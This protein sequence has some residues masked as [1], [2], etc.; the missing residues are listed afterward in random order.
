MKKVLLSLSVATLA[1]PLAFSAC[2]GDTV[3][4]G[5][6]ATPS[7]SG[8]LVVF[9]LTGRPLPNIPLP[10][11]IATF[12]DPTSRTGLRLN[13]SL[14]APT[15]MERIARQGFD[16]MEGW[17]T[18]QPISVTFSREA[19]ADPTQ[20]ALNLDDIKSRMQGDDYD[21]SNDPVYLINL[22]TGVPV[23]LDVGDGNFPL[24]VSS[25]DGY[26]PN[27]LKVRESNLLYETV[28]E[29]AGLTQADYRPSLD[30][31]FD[32]VLDHPNTLGAAR[33]WPG[34]DNLLTWYERE[35]DTLIVRPLL[36]LEEKTAYAV[37][38]TDRLVG[39]DGQPARSPF[40]DIHHPAQ[41]SSVARVIPVLGDMSKKAYFG[42]IAG[43]GLDHVA[44]AW[45]FTTQPVH[46]DM[47][48]LRD[49][50]YGKGP[51]ARFR[52]QFQPQP[53]L[54]Q[55]VG[56]SADP[57]AE[58]PNWQSNPKCAA[59]EGHPYTVTFD[60][61]SDTLH[62]FFEQVFGYRGETARLLEENVSNIDHVVIG[63]FPSPYLMG[64]PAS[65]DPD[66]HFNLD[67]RTGNGDVQQDLVHFYIAVPKAKKGMKQ[68]FPV[69][70]W[71][72]GVT[73]HDDEMIVQAGQFAKQ[74][75]AMISY[76]APEHG[77]V[78]DKGNQ[79]LATGFL[80][81][82]CVAPWIN[83]IAG[84]R[85]HDLN[86]DGIPDSGGLW[87]TAHMFHTR[88]NVRQAILDSM[89]ATR[90]LRTFDGTTLATQDYNNDGKLNDLAGDFDTDGVPDLGGPSVKIYASGESLGGL[91]SEI[92]GGIDPNIS[93]TAPVSGGGG[94]ALDIAL[95]SY[96]VTGA[97]MLQVMS[98]LVVA[99][100]A[101]DR[102]PNSD[103]TVN[104]QCKSGERSV[105][106][107][108]NDLTG[109]K[110]IEIAC[111]AASELGPKQTVVVTNLANH[112]VRCSRTWDHLPDGT[113]DGN[114]RF[115]IP[116]PASIG[117]RIDIQ[118]YDAADAV[119]SYKTCNV[120][121]DAPVGRRINT[122]EQAATSFSAVADPT[123]IC[124]PD[125]TAG[126]TQFRD[127][128]YS[129][130]GPLVAPQD[131]LGLSRQTPDFR[132]LMDLVQAAFDPAD[133]VNFA[134]YY[135]MRPLI[136]PDGQSAGPHALLGVDTVGDGYVNISSGT[137]FARSAGAVPF[138]APN[139]ARSFPEL[140][141]YATPQALFT[142]WDATANRVLIDNYEVEGI[143]RLARTPGQ[144]CN[145]NYV[146]SMV[147]ASPPTTDAT[148]CKD[149][150]FDA[151]WFSEG[152]QLYGQQ[153]PA[154]P[155][156]LARAA[157][158]HATDPAGL[159]RAWAF[160]E[161]SGLNVPDGPTSKEP[162]VALA[163]AYMVPTGQH[164]F[165]T[166]NPCQAFDM[167]SYLQGTIARFFASGGT[168]LYYLSH[169]TTHRCLAADDP[170]MTCDFL[171]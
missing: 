8:P 37:V 86:F 159:D 78:L 168:D 10:N 29:G 3:P 160:R 142:R 120:P 12:P 54:Y 1:A 68:P 15:N 128:F 59:L 66:T 106:F 72:H 56:L 97:V 51:F 28:E 131:G 16:Q 81:Q 150:L 162:L 138:L 140:A 84:G 32:G 71:G 113:P 82:A 22:V 26:F 108:V 7:G 95:R 60:K 76:D 31:D 23:P 109:S 94:G 171:K 100:P 115:R 55:A 61:I 25:L 152:A 47:T 46:E 104:T 126:C 155:L 145:V 69:A 30:K 27:D 103:G 151:D 137:A 123:K 45:T 53:T 166:G 170:T 135:M 93:A 111:L 64:D 112:E 157:T 165:D 39:P 35:T 161:A 14:V 38:L 146:P 124:P 144:A 44:F 133:P 154:E 121:S 58:P 110:E 132:K 148:T 33:Q 88:D 52:D 9:D 158:V 149:T 85:A 96:G 117:D 130:G 91:L 139:G 98:P 20:A 83:G 24:T 80:A 141:D 114:G 77:L 4:N 107:D 48:L 101:S 34:I 125:A 63:T 40:P 129:V 42:D 67:F 70:F 118:I 119:D 156:R 90:M 2:A 99:I 105:R 134:P 6:R 65:P 143:S 164:S 122:W 73:G 102:P 18:Y 43:T 153:H 127:Q 136:G 11:D 19:S 21:F 62:L 147:C 169:P 36:P 116:I 17:G 13:A 92:Q 167:S 50:L 89:Q 87:W 74:G 5:L 49:G 41:K 75:I 163:S 57:A 79:A